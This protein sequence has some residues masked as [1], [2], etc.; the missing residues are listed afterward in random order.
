MPSKFQSKLP[1]PRYVSSSYSFEGIERKK[2]DLRG[3]LH[4]CKHDA[5]QQTRFLTLLD[6]QKEILVY[7]N[8]GRF[9]RIV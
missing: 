4:F 6:R 5:G 3:R 7:G 1:N 2:L 9:V 8:N